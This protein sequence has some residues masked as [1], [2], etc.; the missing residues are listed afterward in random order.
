MT[1][2]TDRTLFTSLSNSNRWFNAVN[3]LVEP[4]FATCIPDTGT[5]LENANFTVP[6]SGGQVPVSATIETIKIE[7][8]GSADGN[9]TNYNHLR[10]IGIQNGTDF[11]FDAWPGGGVVLEGDLTYWGITQQQARDFAIG[12]LYFRLACRA[13]GTLNLG[14][15]INW[16]YCTF[17]YSFPPPTQV[18]FPGPIF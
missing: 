4:G 15:D 7:F 17:G 13:N 5:Q 3:M 10:D 12:D 1:T 14:T 2:L 6:I 9:S 16:V 8:I 11:I 18:T